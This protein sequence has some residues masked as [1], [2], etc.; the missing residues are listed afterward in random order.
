MEERGSPWDSSETLGSLRDS[1]EALASPRDS[2]ETLGSLRDS[3]E[4][5]AS[6]RDSLETLGFLRAELGSLRDSS[7]RLSSIRDPSWDSSW[8]LDSL[9]DSVEL[10][11]YNNTPVGQST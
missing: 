10:N 8:W 4:A 6:P 1:A 7:E 9:E 11:N 3:A 5:L 2:S